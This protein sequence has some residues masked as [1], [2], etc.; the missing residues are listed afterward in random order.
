MGDNA[1]FQE[2]FSTVF[3][4]SIDLFAYVDKDGTYQYISE[5]YAKFSGFSAEEIIGRTP[6]EIFDKGTYQNIILPKLTEC[7]SLARPVNYQT[8][9]SSKK[10]D[11][12]HYLY[13]SYLPHICNV[14]GEVLGVLVIAKDITEIKQ[15]EN[16]LSQSAYT[17]PLTKIANRHYL[18]KKLGE[19]TQSGA[20]SSDRFALMFCD[21]DGF[22]RVNDTYGHAVGDDILHQVASK[23]AQ[24]IRKE[25]V[26]ARYG[27]DEF[28]ILL[29]ELTNKGALSAIQQ[30]IEHAMQKPLDIS[31][32]KVNLGISI[33]IATFPDEADNRFCLLN[34]ADK[35]MYQHKQLKQQKQI[36]LGK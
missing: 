9:V 31:N 13:V 25:D 19:Y 14:T 27:G 10:V 2:I 28:V 26:I 22:K 5:S 32:R 29:P 11:E 8:W 23:L 4:F 16:L 18:E 34:L 12:S 35:R 6:C 30:K 1:F 24:L 17:D 15:A 3:N 33:G 7:K 20:R 21:L 36:N